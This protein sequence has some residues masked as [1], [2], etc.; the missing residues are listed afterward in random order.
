[1]F[2]NDENEHDERLNK[3]IIQKSKTMP[4]P[5]EDEEEVEEDP[6]K[7]RLSLATNYN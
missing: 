6:F 3:L 7:D 1:M 4:V 5:E 2:E